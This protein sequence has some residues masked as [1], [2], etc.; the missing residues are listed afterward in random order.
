LKNPTTTLPVQIESLW[1]RHHIFLS[2]L[3]IY[4]GCDFVSY[5]RGFGK[6]TFFD[7]FRKYSSFIVGDGKFSDM[8]GQSGL[9]SFYRLICSIYFTKHCTA[10][11]PEYFR[12]TSKNVFLPKPLK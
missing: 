1:I 6:K 5:F 11:L 2:L 3:Y 10:F 12:K 4:S 7:V 8:H 9:M